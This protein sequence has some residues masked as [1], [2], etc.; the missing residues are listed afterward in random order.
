[1]GFFGTKEKNYENEIGLLNERQNKLS[2]ITDKNKSDIV[3]LG[4]DFSEYKETIGNQ[5]NEV[6]DFMKGLNSDLA[7][8]K[9]WKEEQRQEAK[10]IRKA[11]EELPDTLTYKEVCQSLNGFSYLDVTS[12]KYYLYENGIL[13]L[14]INPIRNTYRIS[15]DYDNST[16]ELKQYIHI[17]DGVITFDKAVLDYL[18]K[19]SKE[20]QNSINKY[21]RKQNQF[22][23]SKQHLA[24][25]QVI[26]YQAE[27]NKICGINDTYDGKK[28]GMIYKRY[29]LDH[30]NWKKSYEVW[31]E[32]YLEEHP[33]YKYAT[34]IT[35][36]VQEVGDG[37]VLLKIACELF[38]D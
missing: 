24:E 4:I 34:Q 37:D 32:K 1:M 10:A 33:Y 2:E 17:T 26:D 27:I 8:F 19:N 12:F 16:S 25:I 14:K 11:K 22:N 15:S 5:L 18:V 28:W 36:L 7:E 3:A 29:E 21:N 31:K 30:K 20:L 23:K 13:D 35:Y 9:K 6:W 38:V